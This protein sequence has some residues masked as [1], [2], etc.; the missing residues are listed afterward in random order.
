MTKVAPWNKVGFKRISLHPHCFF[1]NYDTHN[2]KDTQMNKVVRVKNDNFTIISNVFLRD[3]KLS[4]KAK[5][6]L[7]VIMGLPN[8][9]EFSINGIC[10]TLKEG[11]TAV[12]GI[13]DELKEHGYC[14][15]SQTRDEYGRMRASDYTFFEE[16]QTHL[17]CT[18]KPHTENPNT[19]NQPQLNTYSIK[20]LFEE[21]NKNNYI[22]NSDKNEIDEFVERMYK[23]YPTKCPLR[24]CYLGKSAK[25]RYEIKKLLKTYSMDEIEIVFNHEINEKFGKHYMQNFLTF[26]K[27]FPDINSIREVEVSVAT[28]N[29]NKVIIGDIEYR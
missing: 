12:Y 9:W 26:L 19:E 16:P 5:G 7:A 27:N 25:C 17:P 29:S 10:A 24:G 2:L 20:D 1:I 28:V 14:F 23:L 6:F 18:E 4:L 13:I 3:E 11:K 8:D 15:A 22:V 21:E